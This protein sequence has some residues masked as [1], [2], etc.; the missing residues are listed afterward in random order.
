[1]LTAFW[2]PREPQNPFTLESTFSVE[3][4]IGTH[5]DFFVEFVGDY[6][7]H[8]APQE[9]LNLGGAYRI[10]HT[11]QID[12]HTGLGIDRRAPAS[13]LGIGYSYR[14]DRLR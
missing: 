7:S 5:A 4:D 14:W 6:P 2:F 1:M 11:Q 13:L 12:V 9:F 10:T 8:L 3:R